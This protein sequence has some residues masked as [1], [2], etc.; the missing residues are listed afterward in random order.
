[1]NDYITCQDDLLNVN[2]FIDDNLLVHL[3]WIVFDF[4][5][6]R[7]LDKNA[8]Y[9]MATEGGEPL[10]ELVS[11]LSLDSEPPVKNEQ[12]CLSEFGLSAIAALLP[13]V[14][15]QVTIDETTSSQVPQRWM[16]YG[17]MAPY[18]LT[19]ADSL[20]LTVDSE[21]VM[22]VQRAKDLAYDSIEAAT[23]AQNEKRLAIDASLE[24]LNKSYPRVGSSSGR[25]TF[26][27]A[28]RS[29]LEKVVW[30]RRFPVEVYSAAE[31]EKQII[32]YESDSLASPARDIK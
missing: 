23:A 8:I 17:M 1:M 20:N 13:P 25:L 5:E 7:K 28:C 3:M 15:I 32:K 27:V 30:G 2:V 9:N 14:Y 16:D 12:G 6:R 11:F 26:E 21:W 19:R 24:K 22:T 18:R 10:D 29:S 31:M 4:L